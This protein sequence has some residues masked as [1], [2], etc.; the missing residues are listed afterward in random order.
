M[1][2]S[3]IVPV[4]NT[5]DYLDECLQ[6]LLDQDIPA[7]DYEIICVNDGSTDGSL[8]VLLH[9]EQQYPNVSVID[10]T[11]GG[12]CK[13]RNTGLLAAKGDY[14]WYIDADDFIE[15]NILGMLHRELVLHNCDR[16]VIDHYEYKPGITQNKQTHLPV[17]TSWKDS[18]VWRSLFRRN[19]LL[20]HNLLFHYP[21][22]S[23]GED[24]LYMYEV[25]RSLPVTVELNEPIYYH[26]DRPGS[27]SSGKNAADE[28]RQLN[29]V[30]REA[31]IMK[32]Y[33]EQ[34]GVFEEETE[35]RFYSFLRGAL[36]S[37]SLM[38][39]KYTARYWKDLKS[40][41]LYP[42][43][44][45]RNRISVKCPGVERNDN[46]GKLLDFLYT[47][48]NTRWGYCSMYLLQRLFR[49]KQLLFSPRK[50]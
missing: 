4:Y 38:P 6:S 42:Y 46:L 8:N 9:Y 45:P 3:F 11:N 40:C 33:Y 34:G 36:Y 27:L 43:K 48:L 39:R 44:Q 7:K 16:L 41:G 24:A 25:K 29:C 20:A 17:N 13:A 31:Q 26:R 49:L 50:G 47:N 18:V 23:F 19:F 2:L 5:E 32:N 37:L 10:Q 12:V 28:I 14:I 15:K 21:E 35:K 30:I 22:L 1:F